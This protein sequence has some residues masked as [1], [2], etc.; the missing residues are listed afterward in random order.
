MSRLGT[1]SWFRTIRTRIALLIGGLI[2]VVLVSFSLFLYLNL[3]AQ[4][5]R[6]IDQGL[7]LNALQIAATVE[8]EDGHYRLAKG[9]AAAQL[10]GNDDDLVRLISPSAQLLDQWGSMDLPISPQHLH[11]T[12]DGL[13][14]LVSIP[15]ATT[16]ASGDHAGT[17]DAMRLITVP[18]SSNGQ[19][20]AYV[21]VARGLGLMQEAIFRLLTLLLIAGPALLAVSLIG[22]YWLAGRAL[23][24]IEAIRLRA[25]SISAEDL[26]QRLTQKLASALPDDEVGRLARTFDAM[27]ARLDESFRR[28]RQFTADASHELRTPLTVI[29][30]EVDVALEQERTPQ[31]YQE[32]LASI[33]DEADRMARLVANL[34]L[35]ARTDIAQL[36]LH[37]EPLDLVDLLRSLTEQLQPQADRADVTLHLSLPAA[38][39]VYGDLD[40]LL[41]VFINLL[42]NAFAYAPG[43]RVQIEGQRTQASIQVA[44]IDT[45]PG[46]PAEDLPNIFE[47][48]YRSDPARSRETGGTGLGLAIARQLVD[49]HGGRI[50]AESPPAG[51]FQGSI[52]YVD[53]PMIGA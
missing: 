41:Q 12:P 20:V 18:V 10:V 30:G 40:R 33:G 22:G 49:L 44:I 15:G 39:P 38:L 29:R 26:S 35:L 37:R 8:N 36:T 19:V 25:E 13:P 17:Q 32:A 46:I 43:S 53:L 7:R 4:L 31:G 45:G 42:E 50:W 34:L 21:Q 5:I 6:V 51:Q 27:L 48:F 28:Q 24:P 47:R 2:L 1:I 3:Q 52:F 11:T 14:T 23:A 16:A 9:D